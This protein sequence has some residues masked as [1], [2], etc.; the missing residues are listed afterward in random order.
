MRTL[1]SFNDQQFDRCIDICRGRARL[2]DPGRRRRQQRLRRH[3]R[4]L[5]RQRAAPDTQAIAVTVTNANEAPTV[6]TLGWR[7]CHQRRT[8]TRLP[9]VSH[10][11]LTT[12]T[13]QRCRRRDIRAIPSFGGA[14]AALFSINS[15]TGVLTFDER[16]RLRRPRPTP[17]R[18]TKRAT[19]SPC[20]V[21]DGNGGT[22]LPMRRIADHRHHDANEAPVITSDGGGPTANLNV[23]ENTTG[24]DDRDIQRCRRRHTELCHRRRCGCRAVFAINSATGVLTFAGRARLRDPGR[25]RRQQRL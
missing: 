1:H 14:D 24:G 8:S 17:D 5:R 2:R 10:G 18:E 6:I 7:R 9:S 20:E 11:S 16:A 4:S 22:D 23:A 3:R 12:V 15:A 21:S 13:I 19:T 25:R